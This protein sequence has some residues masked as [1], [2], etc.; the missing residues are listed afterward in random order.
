MLYKKHLDDMSCNS[1]GCDHKAHKDGLY[2][3][4]RCHP[5]SG[6]FTLR[7]DGYAAISCKTCGLPIASVAIGQVAG[8]AAKFCHPDHGVCVFYNKGM[9]NVSCKKCGESLGSL[10]VRD[11]GVVV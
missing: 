1:P 10:E 3:H 9:L 7:N 2:L 6:T 5:D 4:G 11:E 8:D